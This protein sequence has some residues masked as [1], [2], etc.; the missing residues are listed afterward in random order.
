MFQPGTCRL[1]LQL[2]L[3][4]IIMVVTTVAVHCAGRQLDNTLH[5]RQQLSIVAGDQQTAAPVF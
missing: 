4:A 1:L 3:V 5:T 2:T